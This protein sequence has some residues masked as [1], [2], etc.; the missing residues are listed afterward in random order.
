CARGVPTP[1]PAP[2]PAAGP[3]PL[4]T[5]GATPLPPVP[6]VDGPLAIKVVY[7]SEGQAIATRDSNFILGSIGNGRATL[8]IN[9]AVVPVLPNGSFLAWLPLPPR[10]AP[11]Y[12]IEAVL[13]GDTVRFA[14]RVSLPA[15][16]RPL[17]PDG[18]LVVDT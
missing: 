4:A 18:P 3:A 12:A 5:R 8:R 11:V 7:P 13:G 14:R 2:T 17:P 16:A 15:S 10:T 1:A 6:A 9:G